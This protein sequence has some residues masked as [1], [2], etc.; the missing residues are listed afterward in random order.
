M[1][2]RI[3]L[4]A[5][6]AAVALG[7]ALPPARAADKPVTLEFS[8]FLPAQEKLSLMLQE[9]GRELEKR[10]GGRVKVNYHPGSTLTPPPQTYDS[11]VKDIIDVGFGP[12]GA[13]SGRFPMMEVLDLP[14]GLKSSESASALSNELVRH[15]KPKELSDVKVLFMTSSPPAYI[16]SRKP[17]KSLKDLQGVKLR[18][19]GGTT[20]KVI[21]SLGAVP[22]GI[23]TNDVYDA[24]SKGIIEGAPV[25]HDALVAFK[26]GDSLKHTTL[27]L[28]TS[29]TNNGYFVMNKKRFASLPSDVQ[30][31]VDALSDEY[32]VKLARLWDQK[33]ADAIA[34][35]QRGGHTTHA[36][37]AAE[38]EA[39]F[40]KVAPVFDEYVKDK[41]AKGLP[42]ADVLAFSRDWIVKNQK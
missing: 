13:T 3:H 25:I 27:N 40:R 10:S 33:E 37:D 34:M 35:M 4:L 38:E 15:F 16:Q 17:L 7:L 31:I 22:V 29:Y 12:M 36:L 19:L 32:S 20:V 24:L 8:S 5:L 28:R 1:R 9:W 41:T 30:K 18:A 21:Q 2:H 11:V 6:G 26:W 14:L 42:A 23:P 39:W